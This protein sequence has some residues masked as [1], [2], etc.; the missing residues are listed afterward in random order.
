MA[1]GVQGQS[2]QKIGEA[3][4]GKGGTE[5]VIGKLRKENN[6]TGVSSG[7]DQRRERLSPPR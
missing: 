5:E 1:A 6:E 7:N 4:G 2:E 3:E